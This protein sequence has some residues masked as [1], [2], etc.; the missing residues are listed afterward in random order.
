MHDS[1]A[2]LEGPLQTNL[3]S[4]IPANDIGYD[5]FTYARWRHLLAWMLPFS[6]RVRVFWRGY[7]S[8]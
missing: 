2:C 1:G 4:L 6:G 7:S 8:L 3:S 5:V